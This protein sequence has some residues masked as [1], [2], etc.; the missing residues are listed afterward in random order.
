MG[1]LFLVSTPIGNLR[2][3]TLRA[4]DVLTNVD[5]ILCEDT[6]RSGIF[7]EKLR[8]QGFAKD[9]W[10]PTLVSYYDEVEQ[11]KIPEIIERLIEGR[12]IALISD[13]GTP[14]LSDP[15]YRLVISAKKKNIQVIAVPGASAV[16]TALVSSG[17]PSNQFTF[18][19]YLPEKKGKRVELLTSIKIMD[20]GL[21][22]RITP[23][24]ILYSAPHKLQSAFESI[25]MVFGDIEIVVSRELTKIYEDI[26]SGKIHDAIE[27]YKEPKGEFVILF[28][29]TTNRTV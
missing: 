10:H 14:L 11:V 27:R 23:T 4:I 18:L 7:F 22:A 19:G 26:W 2:D 12:D 9:T 20:E 25:G 3:I 17:L 29:P 8:S 5:Y 28:N 6:R 24:Y 15:G 16:L 13:A 21:K 1:I